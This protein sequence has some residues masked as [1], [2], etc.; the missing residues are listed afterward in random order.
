MPRNFASVAQVKIFLLV[1]IS[2]TVA[3]KN[4]IMQSNDGTNLRSND[5]SN[6]KT[7]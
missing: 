1:F 3:D 5:T 4:R 7:T 6:K 2:P